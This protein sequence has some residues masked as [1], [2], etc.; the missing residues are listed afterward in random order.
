MP[1][2]SRLRTVA[3]FDAIAVSSPPP[4][5]PPPA[6]PPPTGEGYCCGTCSSSASSS[7]GSS[8]DGCTGCCVYNP[9][10]YLSGWDG[11]YCLTFHQTYSD[12]GADC[13]GCEFAGVA[14]NLG[15]ESQYPEFCGY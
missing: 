11:Y 4:A 12:Q 10:L 1:V 5:S 9:G 8:C 14:F 7:E 15:C 2:A 3:P 6:S 13:V